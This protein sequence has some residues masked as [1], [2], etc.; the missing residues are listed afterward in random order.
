MSI[1]LRIFLQTSIIFTKE[2]YAFHKPSVIEGCPYSRLIGIILREVSTSFMSQTRA[3]PSSIDLVAHSLQ[4]SGFHG[5]PQG[6]MNGPV[7]WWISTRRCV[8]MREIRDI[9][10]DEQVLHLQY[11]CCDWIEHVTWHDRSKERYELYRVHSINIWMVH[12]LILELV[13]YTFTWSF[14]STYVK[15]FMLEDVL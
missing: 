1:T 3:Q 14:L 6:S 13:R 12:S 5:V 10:N 9:S 4:R 11:S 2:K 15:S 7:M 8:E